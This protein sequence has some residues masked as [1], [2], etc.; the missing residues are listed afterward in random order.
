MLRTSDQGLVHQRRR[1]TKGLY[2][3][4][5]KPRVCTSEKEEN[6]G[7]CALPKRTWLWQQRVATKTLNLCSSKASAGWSQSPTTD[8]WC[9]KD[10]FTQEHKKFLFSLQCKSFPIDFHLG[11]GLE[12]AEED[13]ECMTHTKLSNHLELWSGHSKILQKK[14]KQNPSPREVQESS[15]C[16][17]DNS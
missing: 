10:L 5:G 1:K 4:R 16:W 15:S 13:R 7:T 3:R 11:R 8:C 12:I 9:P 14:K 17:N 2:I 6:C